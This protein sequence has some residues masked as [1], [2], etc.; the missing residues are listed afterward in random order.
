MLSMQ[1]TIPS[2]ALGDTYQ[3]VEERWSRDVAGLTGAHLLLGHPPES[4]WMDLKKH[5]CLSDS[6]Q[7]QNESKAENRGESRGC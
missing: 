5:Y 4:T 6:W 7:T 1:D 2:T 3:R